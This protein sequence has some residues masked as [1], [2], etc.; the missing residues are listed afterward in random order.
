MH[1]AIRSTSTYT[2]QSKSQPLGR[3]FWVWATLLAA[4][5]T[6]SPTVRAQEPT[7]S[8]PAVAQASS[9]VTTPPIITSVTHPDPT[10]IYTS[11]T[12]TLEWSEDPRVPAGSIKQY[13][14][15]FDMDAKTVPTPPDATATPD[16][17]V[18]LNDVTP[19]RYFFH[20]R[21]EDQYAGLS[22]T[23]HFQVNVG[24]TTITLGNGVISHN[25]PYLVEYSFTVE[26]FS[27]K[28]IVLPPSFIEM[29]CEEDAQQ[30]SASESSVILASTAQNMQTKGMLVLD[31]TASMVSAT[32]AIK[33]MEDGAK[34]IIDKTTTSTLL[35]LYEFHAE[36][37][38]PNRV[39]EMTSNK[40]YLKARVD[41]IWDEYVQNYPAASRC[42]DA[43][44]A[45]LQEF[46]QTTNT[47]ELRFL[48]FLSDG[49]DESSSNTPDSIIALANQ[50]NVRIYPIGFGNPINTEALGQI[51]EGTSGKVIAANSVDDL[52]LAFE[53][54]FRTI[55]GRLTLRWPTLKRTKDFVPGFWLTIPTPTNAKHPAAVNSYTEATAL[56]PGTLAGDTKEGRLSYDGS[57]VL[58]GETDLYLRA[59]YVPRYV[60]QIRL[61]FDFGTGPTAPSFPYEVV[62]IPAEEGGLADDWTLTSETLESGQHWITL[63][64]P[65]P[66]DLTTAIPY[67]WFGNLLRFHFTDVPSLKTLLSAL[68]TQTDD[69]I[70]LSGQHFVLN[71]TSDPQPSMA[72]SPTEV[73][74]L[75]GG[76]AVLSRPKNLLPTPSQIPAKRL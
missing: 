12:V 47:T 18:T 16:K 30:I 44:A 65:D 31:Y 6:A 55:K 50:R 62:K 1:K 76:S 43:V 8:D 73:G 3:G 63:S 24:P 51:A 37:V 59:N 67:A 36:D 7:P 69:T 23:A 74:T 41:A 54:V 32:G 53:D 38:E 39:A 58:N 46:D 10:Q 20:L 11:I 35:G 64:S 17:T 49:R 70:Y 27:N 14:Y 34:Y 56:S 9:L 28:T 68:K 29:Q 21:S 15:L 22:P 60:T 52:Q 25:S 2:T 19:G 57:P 13:H 71:I 66:E 5:L 42:W 72:V 48:V 4:L 40:P 61:R 33:A 45:A 75:S 26:D